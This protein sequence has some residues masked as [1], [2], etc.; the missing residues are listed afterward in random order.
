M[1]NDV[2]L[3]C[4]PSCT[5]HQDLLEGVCT[6]LVSHIKLLLSLLFC[7]PVNIVALEWLDGRNSL[8]Q[9]LRHVDGG[10]NSG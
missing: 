4:K 9:S 6:K 8:S 3:C 7:I 10:I 2:A 1:S 5:A